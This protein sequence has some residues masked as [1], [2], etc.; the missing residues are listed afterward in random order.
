V[1]RSVGISTKLP[2]SVSFVQIFHYEFEVSLFK[3]KKEMND[4][5]FDFPVALISY[6]SKRDV[7]D[8]NYL[9]TSHIKT[10]IQQ[11]SNIVTNNTSKK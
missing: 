3:E 4:F 5:Y 10:K 7:F 8:Y 1:T 6:D 9:Y 2:S 11:S